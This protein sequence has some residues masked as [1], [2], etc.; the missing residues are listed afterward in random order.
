[1][2]IL[3][4][5]DNHL[6]YKES[7]AVLLDDSYDAFEE[8]LC[9]ARR[10]GVDLILQGGDLFHENRPSR[11]CL[12]RTIGLLRQYCVGSKRSEV[13]CNVP[14][15]VDDRN[16]RIAIPVVAIH[17]NHDDP[18]GMRMVSPLDIL[19][20]SGLVNYVGKH[21]QMERIEVFP[22]RLEREHRVAVYGLG[23][24]KDRRLHRM[25]KEGRV[26]F[27]R[28]ADHEEWYNI[29]MVH[30][31]RV[32][33][34]RE[35]FCEDFVDEFFDLVV[36]GHEHESMVM[37]GR[38]LTLQPGST[39]R[40]S[41]CEAE[42]HGKY[43][44]ILRIGA[45]AVL[46][47][48]RLR[49]VRPLLL[50]TLRV[51]EKDDPEERV[52]SK[53]R[54][55]IERGEG[56][57]VFFGHE[58]TAID[59]DVKRFKCTQDVLETRETDR[60]LGE[61]M[62]PERSYTPL[63]RL[64]VELC[65]DGV[66]DKHKLSALF[67]GLVANPAD[68]LVIS[69]KARRGNEDRGCVLGEKK[70]EIAQI[71]QGILKD[72]ELGVVSRSGFN[73]SLEEFVKGDGGAFARMVKRSIGKAVDRIG[74]SSIVEEDVVRAMRGI[75]R[76]EDCKDGETRDELGCCPRTPEEEGRRRRIEEE[77]GAFCLG[78]EARRGKDD[79]STDV[80][81]SFSKYL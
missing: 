57:E 25:F 6:G 68:M 12:N 81:F 36:Y 9:I 37:K 16:I 34:E 31:N 39:V 29:L 18:S 56:R 19:Q 24:I 40:T 26:V 55:M 62:D 2:K 58:V 79:S 71:L 32:A 13:R 28:P 20:S 27:H 72:T 38:H 7:D 47:H 21:E 15:N 23:H 77:V 14:L 54:E 51:G 52:E 8:V 30:Q 46:E 44:Y 70:I 43:V 65:G 66:V 5:S 41:L 3:I 69:R 76:E 59:A 75:S 11:E 73:E 45:E 60:W 1:M 48:V 4:T 17:G 78:K 22:L 49:R 35:H 80:S 50:D 33:R 67:K 42:R 63:V 53:M 10:E 61:V 74:Y 64:K